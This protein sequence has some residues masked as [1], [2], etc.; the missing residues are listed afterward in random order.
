MILSYL[1][2]ILKVLIIRRESKI[3]CFFLYNKI[4]SNKVLTQALI[5]VERAIPISRIDCISIR[6]RTIFITTLTTETYKGVL[7]SS[8]AKKQVTKTLVNM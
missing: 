7:V 3:R 8:R 6:D 2:K 5:A 1:Q 4:K